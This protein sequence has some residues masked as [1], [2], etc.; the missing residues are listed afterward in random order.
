MAG[1]SDDGPA[2]SDGDTVARS[3]DTPVVF[4]AIFD[5][6]Y[7][8]VHRYLAR[9]VGRQRADDLSGEVFAR[10]FAAR[11][12]FDVRQ[13]SCRPWL[14]GIAHNVL[15]THLRTEGRMLAAYARTG[16]DPAMDSTAS[17]SLSAVPARVDATAQRAAMAR[18][19]AALRPAERDVLLLV[20]WADFS[21]EEVAQALQL[22]VGTVRSR[23]HRARAVMRRLLPLPLLASEADRK[24]GTVRWTT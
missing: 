17:D 13:E 4:G 3:L 1:T 19:L 8:Q 6:Y 14:Y 24:G 22:P 11:A 21:Y 23:L 7:R 12:R 16:V 10:A 9:R 2:V 5:R 18:A 20:A 15:R